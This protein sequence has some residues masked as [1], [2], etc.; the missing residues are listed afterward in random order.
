MGMLIGLISLV[1][2]AKSLAS[3]GQ[4]WT[5]AR[6]FMNLTRILPDLSATRRRSSHPYWV[7]PDDL[8]AGQQRGERA[9]AGRCEE[10][11]EK[12]PAADWTG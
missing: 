5:L 6:R 3:D 10:I 4:S 9:A 1:G 11:S 7:P 2:N 12:Y 8:L